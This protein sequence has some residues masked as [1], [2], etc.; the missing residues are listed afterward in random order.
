MNAGKLIHYVTIE[1]GTSTQS[2]DGEPIT[3]WATLARVWASIEPLSGRERLQSDQ[4]GGE[5]TLRVRCRYVSGVTNDS[6]VI[7]GSRTLE[8]YHV[9]NISETNSE[10]EMLCREPT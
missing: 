9:N 6:R 5:T 10:L 8:V 4:A 2:A 7:Q 3:T 1:T